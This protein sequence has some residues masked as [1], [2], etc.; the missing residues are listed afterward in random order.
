MRETSK[1][2]CYQG[3]ESWEQRYLP[4]FPGHVEEEMAAQAASL[5]IRL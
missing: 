1:S 3:G 4:A 2:P 5:G